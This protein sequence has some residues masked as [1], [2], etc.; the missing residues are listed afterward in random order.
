MPVYDMAA[1]Q[2]AWNAWRAA[3]AEESRQID[4]VHNAVKSKAAPE[5]IRAYHE[6]LFAAHNRSM[7]A[8][9]DLQKFRIA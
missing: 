1:G 5:M 7:A 2:D 4:L 8:Y 9:D 3:V 6:T